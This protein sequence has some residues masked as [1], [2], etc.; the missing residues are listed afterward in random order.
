MNDNKLYN[1]SQKNG[2]EK[3]ILPESMVYFRSGYTKRRR[4]GLT[5]LRAGSRKVP[6]TGKKNSRPA[7]IRAVSGERTLP[8]MK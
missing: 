3:L 6:Q 7:Q 2:N 8:G 4:F 5:P 1:K